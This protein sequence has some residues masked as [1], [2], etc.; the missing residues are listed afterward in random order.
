VA[1]I[2]LN[3]APDDPRRQAPR[4][5]CRALDLA[6]APEEAPEGR[7]FTFDDPLWDFIGSV[8]ECTESWVSGDKH[9]ALAE[10]YLDT[11]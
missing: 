10:A 2:A 5:A 11:D 4:G 3:R 6:H 1:R 7:P 8:T 9:R